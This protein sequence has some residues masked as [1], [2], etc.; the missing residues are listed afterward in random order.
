MQF[1]QKILLGEQ[2]INLNIYALFMSYF[3]YKNL[4]KW[5]KAYEQYQ[6]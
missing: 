2:V 6:A 3:C 4:W 1:V 5:F